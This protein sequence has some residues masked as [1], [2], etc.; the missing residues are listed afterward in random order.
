MSL[1]NIPNIQTYKLLITD[2]TYSSFKLLNTVTNEES[3]PTLLQ[4]IH[5]LEDKLFSKDIISL[6][7]Q[8][9]KSP[10]KTVYSHVK[11]GIN[12]AG[13]LVL[14]NNKT[15]G[16]TANKK[17][18]LYKCI[19]DDKHLPVFLVPYEPPIGFSKIFVNKFVIFKYE[20]WNST[21]PQGVLVDTLG[22]VNDPTVF[23]EYQLHCK[24]L[25]ISLSKF[26]NKTKD[27]F[28]KKS[29]TESIAQTQFINQILENPDYSIEDRR[30]TD[31]VFTID[32]KKSVDFDD[33]FSIS[34]DGSIIKI[35]VYIANVFF[36]LE[37]LGLWKSFSSRV[38]TIYL[39]DRKRPMLPTIL[40][41]HLCSLQEGETRF[42]FTMD[43]FWKKTDNDKTY[44][45]PYELIDIKFSHTAINVFKNYRYEEPDLL[46][47]CPEYKQLFE[48]TSAM[49]RS[50]TDSHDLVGYWMTF[51]NQ[52][53]G[54]YLSNMKIG[55]FRSA[56]YKNRLLYDS[57]LNDPSLN[58]LSAEGQRVI[59]N[60]NNTAGQYVIYKDGL[61]EHEVMK[62]KSYVHITSPIRRLVDLLNMMWF[63]RE[64]GL[65]K[66]TSNDSNE[67]LFSWLL[68][69]DYINDS[70]RAIRKIQTDC[71]LIHRCYTSPD[72]LDSV[73]NGIVFGKLVKN[74][75]A[76]M[77]MVYLDSIGILS[78][79]TTHV[80]LPNYSKG[81]F[82]I[83]L[84]E[85]EDRVKKK[86]RL[87]LVE[88][89]E[90]L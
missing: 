46:Y 55:I 60:W 47:R 80:D 70:M 44:K 48:I 32:P 58:E 59:M 3:D 45:K 16:R 6:D 21:H 37:T 7:M 78:R 43:L 51:M 87:H 86:I 49:D 38:A 1:S 65:L 71:E 30:K 90:R 67:F 39:P 76:I 10:Y 25:H 66:S 18:L 24:S 14:E 19:P 35:S 22:D 88:I 2:K 54:D 85:D 31:R 89:F 75:G 83:F 5:P 81:R 69:I 57:L 4:N 79:M 11:S 34:T 42:T 9:L 53:C 33:G 63:S 15:F 36:W 13:V 27:I 8:N 73:Y 62:T 17:R 56:V 40:S 74:D 77:Y 29:K 28:S 82:K 12:I 61:L 84:F 72:I 26:N 20:S 41:D 50:I 52:K 23:Y 68:K 64:I